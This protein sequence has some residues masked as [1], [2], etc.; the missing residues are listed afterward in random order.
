MVP[1]RRK[2]RQERIR[3]SVWPKVGLALACVLVSAAHGAT[4]IQPGTSHTVRFPVD[5]RSPV[6]VWI[7]AR[8]VLAVGEEAGDHVLRLWL[9]EQ[10]LTPG[11]VR[12]LNKAA[13]FDIA[14]PEA[15]PLPLYDAAKNAWFLKADSHTTAYKTVPIRGIGAPQ[16][17]DTGISGAAWAVRGCCR[18]IS[19]GRGP[20]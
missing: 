6:L 3:V 13:V 7:R 9:D 12:V 11:N 18:G 2:P 4:R 20:R 19:A 14:V 15:E 1:T 5:S 16:S 10:P 8:I 17:A